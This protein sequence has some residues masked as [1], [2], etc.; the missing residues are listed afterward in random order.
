[1]VMT[2][3]L[4]PVDLNHESWNR[5]TVKKQTVRV[6]AYDCTDARS[7]TATATETLEG[8]EFQSKGRYAPIVP[9]QSPWELPDVTSCELDA[10]PALKPAINHIVTEDGIQL[11]I[12]PER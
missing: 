1:M 12:H 8:G 5:S 9:Q 4:T 3:R 11:P 10:S 6:L 2:Y 7:K